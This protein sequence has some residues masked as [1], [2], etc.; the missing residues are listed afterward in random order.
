MF[1]WLP[2]RSDGWTDRE[3]AAVGHDE[4]AG[5]AGVARR[6]A[7]VIALD[8]D[9]VAGLHGAWLEAAADE[10]A[11]RACLESP[12]LDL[13]V[14]AGDVEKEPRV[15]ILEAHRGDDALHGDRLVGIEF[16]SEGMMGESGR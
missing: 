3:C 5:G 11:R 4:L 2:L 10:P 8:G 14:G 9:F 12:F 13:A 16:S 6:V 1:A 7:R 15:W